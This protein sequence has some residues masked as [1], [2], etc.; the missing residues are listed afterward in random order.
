MKYAPHTVVQA[1]EDQGGWLSPSAAD[2][3]EE[4]AAVCFQAPTT[5]NLCFISYLFHFIFASFH[6]R[7]I[8]SSDIV[9]R[10]LLL[11]APLPFTLRHSLDPLLHLPSL[12]LTKH[13]CALL[14]L[15]S[16]SLL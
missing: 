7:S 10:H 15:P 3:F 12:S 2:W 14:N 16:L 13:T 5:S 6:L 11:L 8:S 1:L 4:F 9:P